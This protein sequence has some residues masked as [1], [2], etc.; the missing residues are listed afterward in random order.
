MTDIVMLQPNGPE[1]DVRLHCHQNPLI[2]TTTVRIECLQPID[3]YVNKGYHGH[4]YQGDATVR[5][6]DAD[7][8]AVTAGSDSL[9]KGTESERLAVL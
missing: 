6:S 1:Q 7:H 9:P 3:V 8:Q 5:G 4:D 2:S